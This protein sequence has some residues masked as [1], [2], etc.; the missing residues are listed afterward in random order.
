MNIGQHNNPKKINRF[1]LLLLAA[2][3]IFCLL[4]IVFVAMKGPVNN[5]P[6]K[7]QFSDLQEYQQPSPDNI[8]SFPQA[9]WPHKSFKHEWWYLTANLS[10]ENGQRFATQWT[11]FRTSLNNRHWYFAH[12]A[13]AD[14]LVHLAEFRE[15]REELGNV[16]IINFP[17]TAQIDDWIWLSSAQLLPAQLTY[18]TAQYALA[19]GISTDLDVQLE[20]WQVNLSLSSEQPFYLQGDKGFSKKHQNKNIASF[21]YSQP[22]IT[23][24][25]T[26]LWQGKWLN[27]SG[28]GW[29]DREWGSA[30]LAEEQLGW[31]W[32][33]LRLNK[34]QALMIYRIRSL[35]DDFL[36]G[37]LMH[38]N[39]NIETFTNADIQLFGQASQSGDYPQRFTIQVDPI[40]I[41][42]TVNVLNKQQIMRFGIEYFE[43]M[44]TF[45]GSH[46][47]D[48]FVE[49]TG[50]H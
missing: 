41:N 21:Y 39:G 48:G 44:V 24:Q 14:N 40:G 49:M 45:S 31:D 27:V 3:I 33:S 46:S 11:L 32:F 7:S 15:G 4:L 16:E 17:F 38:S 6:L 9:H 13:L 29:F 43:G 50:Y 25:G 26:I 8:I 22:F 36:Y 30:M 18:G 2:I 47:G 34:D 10:A 23:V 42:L 35:R 28:N 5:N 20:S 1:N 37:S 12:A 19:D